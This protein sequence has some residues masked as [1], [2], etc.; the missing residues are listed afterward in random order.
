MKNDSFKEFILDQ[1]RPLGPVECRAMF[2]GHGLYHHRIFFGILF[3]DRLYFKIDSASLAFYTE[4]GMKPFRPS[5]GQTL[6]RYYEVPI[7]LI[8]DSDLLA[9]WARRAI[10]S[11]AVK[12]RETDHGIPGKGTT[13]SS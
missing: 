11:A 12:G 9:V 13:V 4:R 10:E 1:L 8:E 2:G 5:A 6:K 3:K 7:D